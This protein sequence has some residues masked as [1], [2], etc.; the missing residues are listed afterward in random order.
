MVFLDKLSK[1][2]DSS[3]GGGG[4]IYYIY[5]A[6]HYVP[7][8]IKHCKNTLEKTV[9]LSE[10]TIP[11]LLPH[12]NIISKKTFLKGLEVCPCC[13][14]AFLCKIHKMVYIIPSS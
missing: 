6:I 13:W 14:L 8:L 11:Y 1:F 7:L 4:D 5:T 10:I 12:N 2:R 3:G 9:T